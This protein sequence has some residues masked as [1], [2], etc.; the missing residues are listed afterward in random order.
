MEAHQNLRPILNRTDRN[1]TKYAG[2]LAISNRIV[3]DGTALTCAEVARIAREEDVGVT[4]ADSG[5]ARARAAW[6]VAREV[7]ETQPAYG[8]TTGVGANRPADVEWGDADAHGLRLVR[9]PAA[10]TGP[11]LGPETVART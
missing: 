10:G 11:R 2:D 6:E 5:V 3:I 8:R 1:S 7:T 4:V 9:S